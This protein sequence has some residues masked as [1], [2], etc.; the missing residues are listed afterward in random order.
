MHIFQVQN[1]LMKY[2][3]PVLLKMTTV[4]WIFFRSGYFSKLSKIFRKFI[5]SEIFLKNF[6]I[7]GFPA[8][9]HQYQ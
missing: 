3:S 4:D 5:F 7:T 9:Q 6:Q 8:Q 1:E 2:V